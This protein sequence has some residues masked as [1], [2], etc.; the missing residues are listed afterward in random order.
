[1]G[2]KY[3]NSNTKGHSTGGRCCWFRKKQSTR[4][5]I[6]DVSECRFEI[7]QDA[8]AQLVDYAQHEG[9]ELCGVLTGSQIDERTFRI[10]KVSSPCVSRNSRCGCER[11]AVKANT[12]IE[13]DYEASYHTRVYIGEWHTHPKGHPTPS[14]TDYNSI[15]NNYATA[16]LAVPF[17]VMVI[18]GT[19]SIYTSIYDGKAFH[20]VMLIEE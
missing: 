10:S 12:F 6:V 18:V 8:L 16:D 14:G 11:D 4:T 17:I 1:M 20:I 13:K 7:K 5:S 2:R 19:E 3:R 15:I 9:N